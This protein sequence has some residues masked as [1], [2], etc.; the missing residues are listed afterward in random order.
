MALVTPAQVF[1]AIE[2]GIASDGTPALIIS[3]PT[4]LP[5]LS[6][7][8]AAAFTGSFPKLMYALLKKATSEYNDLAANARSPR[9]TMA[10]ANPVGS[11]NNLVNQTFTVT[12]TLDIGDSD[13]APEP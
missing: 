2:V 12:C 5:G 4:S 8:E 1:P 7:E 9:L 6:E 11:G 3:L 10:K 13:V